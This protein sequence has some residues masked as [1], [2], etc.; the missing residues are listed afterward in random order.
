MDE[1]RLPIKESVL[2]RIKTEGVC[3][4]PRLWFQTR[5]C[6]VWLLWLISVV[7]GALAVAVS[8]FVLVY[9]HTA[10]FEVTHDSWWFF[11]IGALPYLWLVILAS[12]L[13]LAVF[14]L[15]H[16]RRGY[17]YP[18][19]Q[20]VGS[21]LLASFGLGF[22]MHAVGTGY[23]VDHVLGQRLAFYESQ[24]KFETN[25]WQKPSEGRL[26]GHLSQLVPEELSVGFGELRFNDIDG[27]I[28]IV[29]ADELSELDFETLIS[30]RK[31]NMF[32]FVDDTALLLFHACGVI[33]VTYSRTGRKDFDLAK[34]KYH[35]WLVNQAYIA[36]DGAVSDR[37]SKRCVEQTIIRRL[38]TSD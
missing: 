11:M 30:G 35:W 2:N 21:S 24:Q 34:A 32:G 4:R 5:E 25:L 31:V 18:L 13:A 19:W 29:M 6:F 38:K 12:M 23:Y 15:R 22:I 33:P 8:L 27:S 36:A 26:V 9:N 37:V 28:W 3:P 7:L 16:S 14:D 20:I 10:L 17:R 1:Q